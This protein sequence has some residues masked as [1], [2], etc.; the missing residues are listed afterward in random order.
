MLLPPALTAQLLAAEVNIVIDHYGNPTPELGE[1]APG[2]QAA[3]RAIVDLDH[4]RL[5]R[6]EIRVGVVGAGHQQKVAVHHRI[7]Y[8]LGADHAA[9]PS[10]TWGV[11]RSGG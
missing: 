10:Q 9:R 2:F 5:A 6:Q 3:L 8:R 11:I 1:N 7:V 4:D